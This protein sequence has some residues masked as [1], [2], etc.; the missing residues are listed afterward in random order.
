[1]KKLN[2]IKLNKISKEEMVQLKGGYETGE[3]CVTPSCSCACNYPD[4]SSTSAN[5][6]ANHARGWHS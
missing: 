3:I 2:R 1:M 6:S 4:I 5:C